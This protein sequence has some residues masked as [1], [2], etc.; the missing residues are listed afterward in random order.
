[1]TT[2]EEIA[3]FE[4]WH[5]RRQF[6]EETATWS[7]AVVDIV[8]ALK[9]DSP[10]R[11]RND[12]KRKLGVEGSEV[13]EKVVRFKC[14]AGL[15]GSRPVSNSPVVS[16]NCKGSPVMRWPGFFQGFKNSIFQM[17]GTRIS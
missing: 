14:S 11:Y 2:K 6:D 8:A 4:R 3:A 10:R 12:L 17:L 9:S 1:M 15:S 13:Y 7:F 16:R 5:V